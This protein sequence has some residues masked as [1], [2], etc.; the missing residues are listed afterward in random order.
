MLTRPWGPV[1]GLEPGPHC[2]LG[3]GAGTDGSAAR[4]PVAPPA[5]TST[6][7]A[8][9]ARNVGRT[10]LTSPRERLV[11]AGPGHTHPPW[12]RSSHATATCPTTLP[13]S[14]NGIRTRVYTLRVECE[15]HRREMNVLLEAYFV[16]LVVPLRHNGGHRSLEPA[17]Q[18]FLCARASSSAV[19]FS[20]RKT[21]AGPPTNL[22]Q[23]TPPRL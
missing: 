4:T 12:P 3:V 17:D 9:A 5:A 1:S 2:A 8:A 10:A 6:N 19:A 20:R 14:P 23:K 21:D 18:S 15:R 11:P 13:C 22:P 16:V 7:A